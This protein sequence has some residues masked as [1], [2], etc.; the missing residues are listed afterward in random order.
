[1]QA[2][3]PPLWHHPI[4]R[5]GWL[6]LAAKQRVAL[7]VIAL[8]CVASLL[9]LLQPWLSKVLVDDG[10]LAGD[11]KVL[12]ISAGLMLLAPLLGLAVESI[13]RFDYLEL[14]S[15]VL[16]GL[17]ERIFEHLQTLSPVYY[18]RVGFGDLVSRFDGDLAE[19]QRFLVDGPL[20][21]INGAFSLLAVVT[22]MGFLDL[23]MTLVVLL[24]MLPL[25]LLH[26]LQKRAAVEGSAREARR[27]STRLSNFFIDTLRAVK[28]IQSANGEAARLTALR[29]RHGDYYQALKTAQQTG[30]SLAAGQRVAGL[31]GTAL[32]FGC[33]GYLLSRGQITMGLLVAFVGY[34]ARVAGP[35]HTLMG[36]LAG[37]Q[38]LRVSLER[39]SEVL[40]A[41]PPR[42]AS[43]MSASLPIVLRGEL[44]L[45]QVSFAYDPEKPV[46]LQACL[47]VPAGS[48][49][50]L[51]G[52]SG[53][54]KSTL[55][56]LLLGHLHPD[57]GNI[58]IDGV[59]IAHV[60]AADLRRRVAVV[61]QEPAFF[62]GTV[63]ENL[64]FVRPQASDAELTDLLQA[65]ELDASEVHLHSPVGGVAAALSRGQRLRLALARAILQN[66]SI[67]VLDETTSAVDR[68]MES[69]L[70]ALVHRRFSGRTCLFITHHAR[71]SQS[72]DMICRLQHGAFEVISGE[73][74]IHAG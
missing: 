40:D 12:A 25:P 5:W 10:A 24:A 45:D 56:D 27:Q 66:P 23:P 73:V 48:K 37:W 26:A 6:L 64:R 18:S 11:L 70:L 32:V 50:L 4:L 67:L 22:L 39:L 3:S 31:A 19:V 59:A 46:L 43:Q 69:Q 51:I 71:G 7:R 54:G 53:G 33:G 47:H 20:A 35:V 28:L 34:S 55:A 63:A 49:V 29:A 57:K 21:L 9:A 16:F 44:E 17:R 14:S 13:T 36:V 15:H 61:D 60:P 2:S 30:F 62:P 72:W 65:V 68:E 42:Q 38:R 58:L 8:S 52:P 74:A 41:E 1:M